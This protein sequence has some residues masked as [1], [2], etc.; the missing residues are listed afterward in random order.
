MFWYTVLLPYLLTI[1]LMGS[2]PF[3]TLLAALVLAVIPNTPQ[4]SKSLYQPWV[5]IN[6]AI[7]IILKEAV[8]NNLWRYLIL[9]AFVQAYHGQSG[10]TASATVSATIVWC[11][12]FD[13]TMTILCSAMLV[14]NSLS[15][16][17]RIALRIYTIYECCVKAGRSVL[18]C[19]TYFIHY[20]NPTD[21]TAPGPGP[22]PEP[23]DDPTPDST[24][25]PESE[26]IPELVPEPAPEPSPEPESSPE[27]EPSPESEPESVPEP[28][29]EVNPEPEP[30]SESE[31]ESVPEP[32]PELVD[33]PEPE[34]IP[35]M[36]PLRSILCG[37]PPPGPR[38][39]SNIGSGS[40]GVITP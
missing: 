14:H 31:S 27:P 19:V 8:D 4:N 33:E 40:L 34:P 35:Q 10:P 38:R 25:E 17:R 28:V 36:P 30:E 32:E 1:D 23:T 20:L 15:L 24:L 2:V 11:M 13:P 37:L 7:A 39:V 12:D 5:A 22:E 16:F 29:L 18:S 6:F 9:L 21:S 3:G 26:L